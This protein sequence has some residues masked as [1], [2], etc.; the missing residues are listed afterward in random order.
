MSEF[1]FYNPKEKG[2]PVVYQLSCTTDITITSPAVATKSPVEDGSSLVDNYFIDNKTASYSGLITQIKVIGQEER[3]DTAIWINSIHTLR[4][5]KKLLTLVAHTEILQNCLIT[6][7]TLSKNKEQGLT[8]W[9]C[10]IEF[11]EVDISER[12]KLVEIKEPKVEVKDEVA[13]KSKSSSSPTKDVALETSFGV[14]IK[15]AVGG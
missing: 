15:D 10:E 7:F 6:Q 8:G 2:E 5:S 9:K 1:Y 3:T 11:Q 12:A 14:D 13:N 4:A